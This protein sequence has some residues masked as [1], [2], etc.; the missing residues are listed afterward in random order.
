MLRLNTEDESVQPGASSSIR[1][2]LALPVQDPRI[3]HAPK[4][5]ELRMVGRCFDCRV[6]RFTVCTNP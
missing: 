3:A 4:L 6:V 2:P 1:I 5:S